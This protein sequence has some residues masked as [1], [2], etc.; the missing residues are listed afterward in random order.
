MSEIHKLLPPEWAEYASSV[1]MGVF[2]EALPAHQLRVDFTLLVMHQGEPTG[3]VT[4]REISPVHVQWSF[5][6]A[7][8]A[9][10][11]K[12]AS[13]EGFHAL[14]NWC[15]KAGYARVT[16][17]VGNTNRIMLAV[18]ARAGFTIVGFRQIGPDASL[19][20]CLEFA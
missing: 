16:F 20:H 12:P 6:G 13:Q 7:F 14:L 2:E 3:Y 18:A 19:E 17:M 1:H 4:C 15:K 10:R 9:I 11:G 8:A 5:G